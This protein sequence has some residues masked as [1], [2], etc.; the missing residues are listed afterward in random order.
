MTWATWVAWSLYAQTTVCPA[1][2]QDMDRL[3]GGAVSMNDGG[4][5]ARQANGDV[6]DDTYQFRFLSGTCDW[7]GIEFKRC[8]RNAACGS[9]GCICGGERCGHCTEANILASKPLDAVSH[10]IA[11][12][13]T[14]ALAPQFYSLFNPRLF[15]FLGHTKLERDSGDDEFFEPAGA[16]AVLTLRRFDGGIPRNGPRFRQRLCAPDAGAETRECGRYEVWKVSKALLGA[17]EIHT[18]NVETGT[19]LRAFPSVSLATKGALTL[20][21]PEGFSIERETTRPCLI[22]RRDDPTRGHQQAWLADLER[23]RLIHLATG[24]MNG[25]LRVNGDSLY[26]NDGKNLAVVKCDAFAAAQGASGRTAIDTLS[27]A[28]QSRDLGILA[29]FAIK[30]SSGESLRNTL[31]ALQRVGSLPPRYVEARDMNEVLAGEYGPPHVLLLLAS[32][33]EQRWVTK[34]PIELAANTPLSSDLSPLVQHMGDLAQT[35]DR[36]IDADAVLDVWRAYSAQDVSRFMTELRLW[37]HEEHGTRG[38]PLCEAGRR[39]QRRYGQTLFSK[40]LSIQPGQCQLDCRHVFSESCKSTPP[41][42]M[43]N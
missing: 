38:P 18:V 17:W 7:V 40:L 24:P 30:A 27:K 34:V 13:L 15:S 33:G 21:I 9:D 23:A 41:E 42:A 14:T 12:S 39:L 19:D 36:F 32:D 4:A 28:E 31:R 35:S 25:L 11:W 22:L 3:A 26:T 6:C 2:R 20:V 43:G 5:W 29:T 16:D 1:A 37:S 10:K 8:T